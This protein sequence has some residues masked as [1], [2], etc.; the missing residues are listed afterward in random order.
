[1]Q[2]ARSAAQGS[3]RSD[4][5]GLLFSINRGAF[6]AHYTPGAY[7]DIVLTPDF[8]LL[9]S[10]PGEAN[11]KMRVNEQGD[12]CIDNGGANAPYVLASSLLEGGAYRVQPGQRVLFVHGALRDV[13]DNE[14]EPCGCPVPETPVAGKGGPSSTP[15]DTAF[16]I[17]VSAGLEAPPKPEGPAV[18][19]GQP[20]AQ[21]TATLSSA[22]PPIAP[23]SDGIVQPEK[24]VD[25]PP[26]RGFFGSIR[27]FFGKIFGAG[28]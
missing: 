25:A 12:T 5:A 17:A 1:M 16:P 10:G 4:D 6:E 24:G 11:L 27:H 15:A 21:V 9:I 14:R 26:R 18:P 2:I 20:H 7:A 22:T 28:S 8:R 13:V 23:Q 3:G 19:P